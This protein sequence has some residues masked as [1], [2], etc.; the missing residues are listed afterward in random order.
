LRDSLAGTPSQGR[1]PH[2]RGPSRW[3]VR[4][5]ARRQLLGQSA[6]P[7]DVDADRLTGRT[8][9]RNADTQCQRCLSWG[10]RT[11]ECRGEA[12]FQP[13]ASRTRRL[14]RG[15]KPMKYAPVPNRRSLCVPIYLSIH[16][17][18]FISSYPTNNITFQP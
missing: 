1:A 13:R 3:A 2:E 16:P 10:H 4:R 18:H 14:L 11:W 8:R 9:P 7:E 15:S 12:V 17:L 5:E 6:G